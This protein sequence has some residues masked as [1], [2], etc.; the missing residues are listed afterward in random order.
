L[1]AKSETKHQRQQQKQPGPEALYL[2]TKF[3][4]N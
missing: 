2:G 1:N 4:R 3:H